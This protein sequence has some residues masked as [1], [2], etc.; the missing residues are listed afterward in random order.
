VVYRYRQERYTACHYIRARDKLW[1]ELSPCRVTHVVGWR[2]AFARDDGWM[3]LE[4]ASVQAGLP[5]PQDIRNVV[6]VALSLAA[7]SDV[8]DFSMLGEELLTELRRRLSGDSAMCEQCRQRARV[9]PA[10]PCQV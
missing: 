5:A 8:D 10:V 3:L 2:F 6:T 1:H 4:R 9:G 7:T